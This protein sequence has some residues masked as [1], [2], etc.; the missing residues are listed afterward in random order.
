VIVGGTRFFERR[1]IMDTLAYLRLI[2]NPKDAGAFDRIVN[3]P[4]RGIG[5]TSQA[6]LLAWAAERGMNP[7]EAAARAEE[8]MHLRGN[9]IASLK[10]F[11]GIIRDF[12]ELA[13]HLE[14]GELVDRLLDEVGILEALKE[15]GPEGVERADNV[16]ELLAGA[17]E[18]DEDG[19]SDFDEDGA[20]DLDENEALDLDGRGPADRDENQEAGLTPLDLFLQK[21]SLLTD[22][23]RQDPN[24]I[25]ATLMTVHNAKGLEYTYVFLCGLEDGLFPLARAFDDPAT[26]EEERRLLYV[27]V[28]RAKRKVW[29]SWARTRRRAGEV[30]SCIRSSFLRP[31]PQHLVEERKTPHLD[32]LHRTWQIPERARERAARIRAERSPTF[33]DDDGSGVYIDYADAQ[34]TP[35]FVKG[36]RVRH[37]QFGRGTIRELSGFGNDVKAVVEFE[38]VGRKKV[39]LRFANLQKEL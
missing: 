37:P 21:V 19:A 30:L 15:E 24:A 35:R 1:E 18:F 3:W 10:E 2:S 26:L 16:R 7:L 27:G 25:A 28:T 38:R 31:L 8:C 11:A 9:A 5:E 22:V 4:R 6:H 13:R 33:D 32:R 17:H 14:V 29:L 34:E 23:D 39:I 12:A 36:E 20:S